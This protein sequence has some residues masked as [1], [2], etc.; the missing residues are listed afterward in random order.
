MS[1]AGTHLATRLSVDARETW[2]ALQARLTNA[3]AAFD[4]G[5]RTR[6]LDEVNAA[7]TIAKEQISKSR[8]QDWSVI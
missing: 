1:P 4:A 6:A 5:D 2:Q 8:H 7:L 3:R